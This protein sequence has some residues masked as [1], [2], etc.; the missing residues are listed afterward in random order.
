M[1]CPSVVR[2]TVPSGP[3]VARV[4]V[5]GG[6]SVVRLAIP[7]PPGSTAP[8]YRVRIDSAISGVIYTGRAASGTSESAT[9]WAIKRRTFTAAGVLTGT[10]T[11]TG[12]WSNRASLTYT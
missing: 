5:P 1:T 12:A 3:A 6:P 8:I 2:L 11:A 4:T 9:G 10:G 7:G